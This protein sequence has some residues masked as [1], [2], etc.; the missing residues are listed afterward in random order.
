M[1]SPSRLLNVF[2]V[3]A[4]ITVLKDERKK[5]HS[6]CCSRFLSACEIDSHVALEV[7]DKTW[8]SQDMV[9]WAGPWKP[10][11]V[12]WNH[13]GLTKLMQSERAECPSQLSCP[14]TQNVF[15]TVQQG[16][17]TLVFLWFYFSNLKCK[18]R[19]IINKT[20]VNLSSLIFHLVKNDD[21]RYG[22]IWFSALL[23]SHWSAPAPF[24][25]FPR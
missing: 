22:L 23:T 7:C 17:K 15:S 13:K 20:R 21:E 9:L 5:E 8:R 11:F 1:F 16:K 12:S 6:C 19:V 3:S 4:S 24:P 10:V 18:T 25:F 2:T 14:F